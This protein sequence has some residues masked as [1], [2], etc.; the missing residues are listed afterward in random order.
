MNYYELAI[1]KSP[2]D[3]LIYQSEEE[4]EIGTLV[5][6]ILANRKI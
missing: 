5:E 6:V 2:L 1:L 4:L 3:N